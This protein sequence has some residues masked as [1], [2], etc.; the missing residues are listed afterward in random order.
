MKLLA[1]A[2][3]SETHGMKDNETKDSNKMV[4]NSEDVGDWKCAH[5]RA[6]HDSRPKIGFR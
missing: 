4:A 1:R 6:V 2:R 5:V 3:G